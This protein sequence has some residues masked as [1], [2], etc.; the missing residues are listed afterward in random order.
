MES[1]RAAGPARVPGAPASKKDKERCKRR[2]RRRWRKLKAKGE[3]PGAG[4]SAEG[5]LAILR[6]AGD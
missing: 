4:S 1:A 6:G 3:H 5:T 2:S